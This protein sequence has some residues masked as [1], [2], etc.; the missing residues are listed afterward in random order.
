MTTKNAWR[1]VKHKH[2]L[3]SV[4]CS[5]EWYLRSSHDVLPFFQNLYDLLLRLLVPMVRVKTLERH[6]DICE[7][8]SLYCSSYERFP[9]T[10]MID[11]YSRPV[12]QIFLAKIDCRWGQVRRDSDGS[13][14]LST[15]PVS[16]ILC[17]SGSIRA[18]QAI[19]VR[20]WDLQ[21]GLNTGLEENATWRDHVVMQG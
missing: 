13:V 4:S 21:L 7:V 6:P 2:I 11:V 14:Y 8:M 3:I 10:T 18:W 20:P 1:R 9:C 16:T 5:W 12:V 15:I 17:L 19:T